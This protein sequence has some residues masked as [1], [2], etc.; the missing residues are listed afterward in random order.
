MIKKFIKAVKQAWHK[1][2]VMRSFAVRQKVAKEAYK[3]YIGSNANLSPDKFR[4]A[5]AFC[6][7]ARFKRSVGK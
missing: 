5:N 2:H 7:G 1:Y 3:R 4:E 6:M